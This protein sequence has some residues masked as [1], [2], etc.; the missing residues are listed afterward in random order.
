MKTIILG[1]VQYFLVLSNQAGTRKQE[2]RNFWERWG[3]QLKCF[4]GVF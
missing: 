2:T 1:S 3:V 4:K